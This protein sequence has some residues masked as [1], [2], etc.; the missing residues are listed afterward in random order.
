M[1]K[2]KRYYHFKTTSGEEVVIYSDDYYKAE[3]QADVKYHILEY[4][5]WTE[6]R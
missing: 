1:T 2:E 6:T 3:A 4:L 5:G